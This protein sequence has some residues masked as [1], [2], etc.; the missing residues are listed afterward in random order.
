VYVVGYMSAHRSEQHH[1]ADRIAVEI[2]L[3]SD[4][5]KLGAVAG[6][7]LAPGLSDRAELESPA[8][9]RVPETCSTT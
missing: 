1:S 7:S 8:L 2:M 6:P 9:L 5:Y 3:F 4:R